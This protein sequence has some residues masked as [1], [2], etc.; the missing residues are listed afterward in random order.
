VLGDLHGV[1]GGALQQ[2]IAG[3]EHRDRA[4]PGIAGVAADAADQDVV[5]AAGVLGYRKIVALD[6]VDDAKAGSVG[7]DAARLLGRDRLSA[8]DG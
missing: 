1:E 8:F 5:L 2:L 6:I 4:A 7:K 3:N